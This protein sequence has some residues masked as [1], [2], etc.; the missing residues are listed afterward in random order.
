MI[1]LKKYRIDKYLTKMCEYFSRKFYGWNI[2][3]K[4]SNV[5]IECEGRSLEPKFL[6]NKSFPT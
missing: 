6:G 4:L 1:L 5:Q 3:P 2:E